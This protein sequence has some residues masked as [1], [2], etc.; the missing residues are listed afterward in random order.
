MHTAIPIGAAGEG[1]TCGG[2]LTAKHI[3]SGPREANLSTRV[4]SQDIVTGIDGRQYI[5]DQATIWRWREAFQND[6]A[7]RMD[8]TVADYRHANHHPVVEVNGQA[9]TAPVLIDA[10]VDQPVVLDASRSKDPDGQSLHYS[11][12]HY[13]EA[14]GTGTN[15]SGVVIAGG[16]AAKAIVT[17]TTVCR[18]QWLPVAAPCTGTGTAHIILAV[19]DDG[20]PRLTSYRRVILNV[21]RTR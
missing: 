21:R 2:N 12:F 8:W 5:S 17:P 3:R 1:G 16:D 14:G 10:V 7:A 9:G 11:W 19:S 20:S 13:A 18:P 4:T 6:F 15:L